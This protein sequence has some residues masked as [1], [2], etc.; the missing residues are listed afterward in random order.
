MSINQ[1]KTILI[2]DDEEDLREI[3]EFVL[4]E[5]NYQTKLASNGKEALN[6]LSTEAVD[7]V[8]SDIRMPDGD[9]I[10]LLDKHKEQ[11]GTQP[12]IFVSGFS[13]LTLETA[14]HK[15]ADAIF[16]KPVNTEDLVH[17]V[18]QCLLEPKERW[19]KKT[20]WSQAS[21]L[22]L[23]ITSLEDA[24]QNKDF[25]LGTGGAFVKISEELP[26]F[27]KPLHIK[28]IIEEVQKTFEGIVRVCWHRNEHSEPLPK[29]I[30]VEFEELTQESLT[31]LE[32]Y[33]STHQTI[34]KIPLK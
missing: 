3:I 13:D 17:Y 25:I 9:G 31:L 21:S 34:S 19:Q 29:G 20:D 23:S 4:E 12:V 26:C 5:E 32:S 15:G 1:D 6:I 30:G 28:I 24:A 22:S 33:L 8:V 2:V 18:K 10:Y 27:Q 16:A 14:Y 7:L 11:K